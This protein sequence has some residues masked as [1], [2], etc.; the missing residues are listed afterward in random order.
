MAAIKQDNSEL[1]AFLKLME[2]LRPDLAARVT[3]DNNK[4]QKHG[5]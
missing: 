2:Q 3:L 1:L 4:K 5:N